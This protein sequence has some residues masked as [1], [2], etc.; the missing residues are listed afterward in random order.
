MRPGQDPARD[1]QLN[2]QVVPFALQRRQGQGGGGAIQLAERGDRL[3]LLL[4]QH[5][6][7]VGHSAGGGLSAG[8]TE[9]A[10]CHLTTAASLSLLVA[11]ALAGACCLRAVRAAGRA[12]AAAPA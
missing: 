4:E 11:R 8:T 5:S 2:D 6:D 3:G 10:T 12:P 9:R 1:S 7:E